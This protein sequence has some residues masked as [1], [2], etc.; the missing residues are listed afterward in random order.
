MLRKYSGGGELGTTLFFDHD[1][2]A[3]GAVSIRAPLAGRD[4]QKLAA[5]RRMHGRG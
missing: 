5:Y 2:L 1:Y 4:V 3:I